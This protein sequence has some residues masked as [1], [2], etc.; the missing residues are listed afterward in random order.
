LAYV[1]ERDR[2]PGGL[3]TESIDGVGD[4]A[5]FRHGAAATETRVVVLDGNHIIRLVHNETID[6][7]TDKACLTPLAG[8]A[9]A[10]APLASRR[11]SP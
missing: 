4:G 6:V 3:V 2:Q 5:F 11:P 7:A 9:V 10:A 1:A 8:D